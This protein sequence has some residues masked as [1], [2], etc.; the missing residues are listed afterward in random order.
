MLDQD[1]INEKIQAICHKEK[2]RLLFGEIYSYAFNLVYNDKSDDLKDAIKKAFEK[3][4]RETQN[5]LHSHSDED[6][7]DYLQQVCFD[8]TKSIETIE[9]VFHPLVIDDPSYSIKKDLLQV[10]RK[11]VFEKPPTSE[12][13]T[14]FLISFAHTAVSHCTEETKNVIEIIKQLVANSPQWELFM[15]HYYEATDGFFAEF[16]G[17]VFMDPNVIETES[18][19]DYLVEGT[20]EIAN[21]PIAYIGCAKRI[22]ENQ[23][24]IWEL[25]PKKQID[26]LKALA[27]YDLCDQFLNR[28]FS[29]E[30]NESGTSPAEIFSHAFFEDFNN[31]EV[32]CNIIKTFFVSEASIQAITKQMLSYYES[33][34]KGVIGPI[35][36]KY[37]QITNASV[38]VKT[39]NDVF[40]KISLLYETDLHKSNFFLSSVESFRH[41][42]IADE[43]IH[44][45][46][47]AASVIGKSIETIFIN[48]EK[49]NEE[50]RF[51]KE[52]GRIIGYSNNKLEFITVHNAL[53]YVRLCKCGGRQFTIENE[54]LSTIDSYF[55][56][57]ITN[58]FNAMRSEFEASDVIH[59]KWIK[60]KPDAKLNLFVIHK[61]NASGFNSSIKVKLPPRL[62]SMQD[63]FLAFYNKENQHKTLDF[64]YE[65]NQVF[66]EV[67]FLGKKF[68]V[69]AP[70]FFAVLLIH[71]EQ[72][73]VPQ[74]IKDIRAATGFSLNEI[75]L[76]LGKA[77][78]PKFMLFKTSTKEITD[79]TT[80]QWNQE[81]DF[82]V[83]KITIVIQ[84][85]FSIKLAQQKALTNELNKK[86]QAIYQ[87]IIT[88]ILKENGNIKE[89]YLMEMTKSRIS[90]SFIFKPEDFGTALAYFEK[91]GYIRRGPMKMITYSKEF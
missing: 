33:H 50:M 66:L 60:Y 72:F 22:I 48:N 37:T 1:F 75:K 31:Y 10:F 17:E 57:E 27:Q 79:D 25:F 87:K 11:N 20:Q 40:Q 82:S 43:S 65:D 64:V 58:Q 2:H 51:I 49:K 38:I 63:E 14:N 83:K 23:Q 19:I 80:V 89:D 78:A 59:K 53:M 56:P 47:C 13:M 12:K 68:D 69:C 61:K 16:T 21:N 36:D 46:Y 77:M 30:K 42:I 91:K 29:T 54:V 4:V 76:I 52:I 5:D 85:Q 55:P 81:F 41:D 15:K 88:E 24:K 35:S 45:E 90:A 70:L 62:K 74:K 39:V 44:F 84:T 71:M 26:E 18:G 8:T 34:I 67:N 73:K 7:N 32:F 6:F 9:K 3:C 86:K 28:I